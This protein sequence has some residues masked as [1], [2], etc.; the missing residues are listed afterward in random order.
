MSRPE[1]PLDPHRN[2]RVLYKK[3]QTRMPA[4]ALGL[5][6]FW[7]PCA[8]PAPPVLSGRTPRTPQSTPRSSDLQ[9]Q[10]E[11]LQA[12]CRRISK[13]GGRHSKVPLLSPGTPQP[14]SQD[15]RGRY[16]DAP[17]HAR[18]R[19]T[20][21]SHSRERL[22]ENTWEQ[23]ARSSAV[24]GQ[25]WEAGAGFP[26]AG[27]W[28]PTVTHPASPPSQSLPRPP[29]APWVPGRG[30]H[31]GPASP[32]GPH[33]SQEEYKGLFRERLQGKKGRLCFQ[34]SRQE[35]GSERLT[36]ENREEGGPRA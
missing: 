31:W 2:P 6:P 24:K 3:C 25:G 28:V 5:S 17:D 13:G 9:V 23:E 8:P 19:S 11:K 36:H 29:L 32:R 20:D 15:E 21:R 14:I 7:E 35:P 16:S 33:G 27:S 18:E 22:E 26:L 10:N 34:P 1:I 4:L 12:P 30:S